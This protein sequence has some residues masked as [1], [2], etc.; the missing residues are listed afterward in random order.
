MP[1]IAVILSWKE[2][3]LEKADAAGSERAQPPN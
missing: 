2:Q 3:N 1:L